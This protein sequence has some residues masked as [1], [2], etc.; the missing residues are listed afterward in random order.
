M[1]TRVPGFWQK[2]P[3]GDWECVHQMETGNVCNQHQIG[4]NQKSWGCDQTIGGSQS[5]DDVEMRKRNQ[6]FSFII[7]WKVYHWFI[8]LAATHCKHDP[9]PAWYHI[10]TKFR[11]LPNCND[12]AL[13]ILK[14]GLSAQD[15]FNSKSFPP[16]LFNQSW[17]R[18]S[19]MRRMTACTLGLKSVNS[20]GADAT[21][22][23]V[24]RFQFLWDAHTNC[25]DIV[26]VYIYI[27]T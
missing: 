25:G 18:R 12:P 10:Y 13:M 5:C 9:G 27:S 22:E 24:G 14:R 1:F 3:N 20:D 23:L 16:G 2:W 15:C 17:S 7:F 26:Y 4:S 6:V 19:G 21:W 11:S 8:L